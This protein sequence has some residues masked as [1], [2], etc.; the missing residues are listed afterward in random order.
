MH[1]GKILYE[2]VRLLGLQRDET[3]SDD[4]LYVC[5]IM[6]WMQGRCI[7]RPM[8][9]RIKI[10]RYCVPCTYCPLNYRPCILK[11]T[12]SIRP[13]PMCPWPSHTQLCMGWFGQRH[14]IQGK[15]C[16]RDAISKEIW[17]GTHR[18]GTYWCNVCRM[19]SHLWPGR[20][21]LC[22]PHPGRTH[23]KRRRKRGTETK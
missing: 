11:G 10:L 16:P 8:C 20:G 1:S 6:W 4:M 3:N 14:N 5:W 12:T 23:R 15:L 13:R 17:S 19:S 21:S 9:P 2:Y 7:P 18:S 22:W